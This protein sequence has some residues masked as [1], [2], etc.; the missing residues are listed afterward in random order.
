MRIQPIFCSVRVVACP[1]ATVFTAIYCIPF[2]LLENLTSY[3]RLFA[4]EILARISN[5]TLQISFFGLMI[6]FVKWAPGS[7]GSFAL[8][9]RG[10]VT[11]VP[12]KGCCRA[13]A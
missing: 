13:K 3:G 4:V 7:M 2:A 8:P 11:V 6:D 5:R 9:Q 10:T 12:V 1:L